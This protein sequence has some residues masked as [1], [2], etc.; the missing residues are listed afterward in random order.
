MTDDKLIEAVARAIEHEMFVK[1]FSEVVAN[2]GGEVKVPPMKQIARAALRAVRE[3]QD[4]D[5]VLETAI[6]A[7]DKA[8]CAW[9][10]LPQNEGMLPCGCLLECMEAAL[11]AVKVLPTPPKE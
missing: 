2:G 6:E 9:S 10:N 11:V 1:P 7:Y 5:S 4:D 3:G 8:F